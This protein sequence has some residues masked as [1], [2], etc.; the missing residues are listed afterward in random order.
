MSKAL[1]PRRVMATLLGR[2]EISPSL[3][4]VPLDTTELSRPHYSPSGLWTSSPG[5][6]LQ[7]QTP[8]HQS[9]R[10]KRVWGSPTALELS[11]L[12]GCGWGGSVVSPV[13]AGLSPLRP[14]ACA[15]AS[16]RAVCIPDKVPTCPGPSQNAETLN[17]RMF[18]VSVNLS[19][20]IKCPFELSYDDTCHSFFLC[21]WM[22]LIWQ[23]KRLA[24]G[25]HLPH[26]PFLKDVF[27]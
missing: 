5:G 17:G 25:I 27:Y 16:L 26:S 19:L 18:S 23:N 21:F 14:P 4:K 7:V 22:S 8:L 12:R 15:C 1:C 2:A 24:I 11:V 9:R 6:P 13:T 3:Q 20:C 10:G